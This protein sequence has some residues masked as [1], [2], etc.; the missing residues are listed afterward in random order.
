MGFLVLL[1]GNIANKIV[2]NTALPALGVYCEIVEGILHLDALVDLLESQPIGWGCGQDLVDE[3][4]VI[5]VGLL[6]LLLCVICPVQ[7][8]RRRLGLFAPSL[9]ERLFRLRHLAFLAVL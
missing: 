1:E 4:A 7:L 6:Q 3:N 2:P 5:L 8:Q 9:L